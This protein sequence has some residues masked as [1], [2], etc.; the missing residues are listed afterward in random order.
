MLSKGPADPSGADPAVLRS[1][2]GQPAQGVGGGTEGGAC[3]DPDQGGEGRK[4]G[5]E[6]KARPLLHGPSPAVGPAPAP[7][8]T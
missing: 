3:W 8:G 2:A 5:A 7:P 4:D 1:L 6:P